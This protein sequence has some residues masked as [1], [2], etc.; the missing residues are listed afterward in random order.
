MTSASLNHQSNP[1]NFSNNY[2]NE[3]HQ[4][5]SNQPTSNLETDYRQANNIASKLLAPNIQKYHN[6]QVHIHNNNNLQ[7]PAVTMNHVE[8]PPPQTHPSPQPAPV[9]S[10]KKTKSILKKKSSYENHSNNRLESAMIVNGTLKMGS[11]ERTL[12][13]LRHNTAAL[14]NFGILSDPHTVATVTIPDRK[15]STSSGKRVTFAF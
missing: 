6:V 9:I 8:V 13:H 1:R 4:S 10:H 12:P 7:E 2:N 14:G 11:L 3:S 15:R 5:I